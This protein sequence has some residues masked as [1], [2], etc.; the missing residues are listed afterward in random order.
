[1]RTMAN[2]RF[3]RTRRL[4]TIGLW[5][6]SALVVGWGLAPAWAD[7]PGAVQAS[8]KTTQTTPP[9]PSTNPAPHPKARPARK[10]KDVVANSHPAPVGVGQRDPFKLPPPPGV[11]NGESI[12][13]GAGGPLP[14]GKR[15]LLVSQLRLEG[16]VWE[17]VSKKMIAV[18]TNDRKLAYFLSENDEV[19]N[20]VVSKITRDSVY[21]K[22]NVLAPDGR[23]STREVVKKLGAAPGEVR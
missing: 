16:V 7:Q 17:N 8:R 13:E 4:L 3:R 14:P 20:G 2:H 23:V 21:F 6:L 22:E 12:P 10:D 18:V 1:M 5:I 9:K 11:K 19:Y 15:G